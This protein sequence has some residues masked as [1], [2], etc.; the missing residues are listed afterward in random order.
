M[1]VVDKLY[2]SQGCE[3]SSCNKVL[4]LFIYIY[5]TKLDLRFDGYL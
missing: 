2:E 3:A 4:L 1:A 5:I